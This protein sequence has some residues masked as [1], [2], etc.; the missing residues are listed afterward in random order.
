MQDQYAPDN[1][2]TATHS[3]PISMVRTPPDFTTVLHGQHQQFAKQL[4]SAPACFDL[5]EAPGAGEL[6]VYHAGFEMLQDPF[7][8]DASLF[9]I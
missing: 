4:D 3:S 9:S 7:G 2:T 8:I 5:D 1:I 6:H